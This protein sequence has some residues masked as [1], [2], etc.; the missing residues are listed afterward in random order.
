MLIHRKGQTITPT[1]THVL[2]LPLQLE[3][4]IG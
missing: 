1:P 4:V 3:P 2:G